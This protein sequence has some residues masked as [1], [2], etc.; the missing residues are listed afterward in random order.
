MDDT[1]IPFTQY[2]LPNGERKPIK[3]NRP[4]AIQAKARDIMALGYRFEAEIL[5]DGMVSLTIAGKNTDVGI[6]ICTNG[7]AVPEAV[8]KLIMEFDADRAKRID[9]EAG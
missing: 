8:D 6:M 1:G 4:F 2:L 5:T 9:E 7:P 3:I